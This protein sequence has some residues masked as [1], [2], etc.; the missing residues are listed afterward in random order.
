M[1]ILTDLFITESS[2]FGHLVLY[3]LSTGN[4]CIDADGKMCSQVKPVFSLIGLYPQQTYFRSSYRRGGGGG[5][6]AYE[7]G[8]DAGRLA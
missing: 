2:K 1:E 8:G 7:R 5:N 3:L 4:C 6:A